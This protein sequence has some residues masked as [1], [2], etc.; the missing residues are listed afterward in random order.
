MFDLPA[1]QKEAI[2]IQEFEN[3]GYSMSKLITKDQLYEILSDK[4]GHPYD[5][6]VFEELYLQMRKEPTGETTLSDY[7]EVWL[8]AD[9]RLKSKI[10]VTDQ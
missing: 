4:A 2:L 10:K 3:S 7:I 1:Q 8:Q 9:Q 6:E 5:D